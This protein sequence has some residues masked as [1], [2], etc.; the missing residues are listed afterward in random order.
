MWLRCT[1]AHL[2]FTR[3]L[4]EGLVDPRRDLG[5]YLYELCHQIDLTTTS[6]DDALVPHLL[7]QVLTDIDAAEQIVRVRRRDVGYSSAP[8]SFLAGRACAV[9]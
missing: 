2:E 8:R 7:D 3:V 1:L 9:R 6:R 4:D 5:R